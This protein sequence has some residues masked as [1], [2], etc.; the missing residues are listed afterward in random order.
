MGQKAMNIIN[1]QMKVMLFFRERVWS[2]SLTAAFCKLTD[3]VT[4][5][6]FGNTDDEADLRALASR[7]LSD[8]GHQLADSCY[9]V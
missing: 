8:S 7:S 2:I 6:S 3:P 9:K 4:P 5:A 1:N